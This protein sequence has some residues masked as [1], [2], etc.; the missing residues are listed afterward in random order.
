MKDFFQL[1]C[2]DNFSQSQFFRF[3]KWAGSFLSFAVL[4]SSSYPDPFL[5]KWCVAAII[6]HGGMQMEKKQKK[7]VSFFLE[8]QETI[9]Q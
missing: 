1:A 4:F 9:C 2:L 5:A 3:G 6:C 8:D 7:R